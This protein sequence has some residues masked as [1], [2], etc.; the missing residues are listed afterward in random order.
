MI[1]LDI[2]K[3]SDYKEFLKLSVE[4]RIKLIEQTSKEL[5]VAENPLLKEDKE[6][7]KKRSI[8][9]QEKRYFPPITRQGLD[10]QSDECIVGIIH[11]SLKELVVK[12]NWKS[13]KEI[14]E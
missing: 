10:V 14:L 1:T 9:I 2:A 11:P 4:E 6:Y 13:P 7:W 3:L 12:N 8:L 5:S